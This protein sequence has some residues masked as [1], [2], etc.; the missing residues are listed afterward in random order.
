MNAK[1]DYSIRNINQV[2]KSLE[3][4][5]L[6]SRI[7]LVLALAWSFCL[8]Q[9]HRSSNVIPYLLARTEESQLPIAL[10]RYSLPLHH[11][12]TFQIRFL[13][14]DR[15][16]QALLLIF[17]EQLFFLYIHIFQYNLMHIYRHYVQ[18]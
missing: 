10:N 2:N 4:G 9:I 13:F 5:K 8:V 16:L 17:M 14:L 7:G 1:L 3:I 6:L 15:I 11:S 12:F 18:C